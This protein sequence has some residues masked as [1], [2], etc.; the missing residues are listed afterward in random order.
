VRDVE[1]QLAGIGISKEAVIVQSQ[2]AMLPAQK[3]LADA[4]VG[5]ALEA[6]IMPAQ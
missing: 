3:K 6:E 4:I 2:Y 5:L 1:Q